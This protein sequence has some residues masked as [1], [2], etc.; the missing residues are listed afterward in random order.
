M[1]IQCSCGTKYSFEI[2]PEMAR[3][4]VRFVCPNCGLDSSEYVNQLIREELAEQAA[5]QSLPED[6]P[7]PSIASVPPPAAR[8]KISHEQKPAEPTP[9]APSASG[10]FCAKHRTV[11]ATGKCAICGTPIC[12]QCMELFG[13]FC[14][15]LCKN[16]ADLQGVAAPVYAGQKSVVEAQFWRKAGLIFG[17]VVAALVLAVGVWIWYAWFGSVPHQR[18][19]VRFDDSERSHYGA[20]RLVGDDQIVF[21]HGGIL[22]RYDLKTK[23]QVWQQTLVTQQQVADLVKSEDEE[24]ARESAK[25]GRDIG[26]VMLSGQHEKMVR[27]SLEGA[28]KLRVADENVWVGKYVQRTNPAD[29][30]ASSDYQLTR[31]DWATGKVAQQVTVPEDA[32]MFIDRSNEIVLL[33]HTEV[34]AQFVTHVSLADGAERTEEFHDPAAVTVAVAS[35]ARR[36][37]G[38]AGNS[39]GG[40]QPSGAEKLAEEAQNLNLP[41]RIA[42]PALV[43]GE[44]HR[45]Q[46]AAALQDDDPSRPRPDKNFQREAARFMLLPDLNGYIQVAVR[47][48]EE[49]IVT[50]E[51]MKA[52]PKK[53]LLDSGNVSTGNETTAVNEQLNEMQRNSGNTSVSEDQSRYQV[54]LHRPDSTDTPDWTGEVIGPPEVFPLK[55]VNVLAGGRSV[56]VFDKANK[57]LWEASLTYPIGGGNRQFGDAEPQFGDGPVVEHGDTLYVFDQ[58][59]LSAY[60]LATGNARWRLPSIGIVGLFFDDRGMIYVNTTTGNPDDIKYARQID[61]TKST[62]AVLL[63]LDPRTGKT[64]W[65]VKPGGFISYLSGKFIYT[66]ES[67]DPNP[68]DQVALS[69]TLQGLQRPPYLR[70][71]RINPKD[72]RL[73]WEHQQDRCP[74]DIRFD[75]NS[76]E[77]VFKREVQVLHYLSF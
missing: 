57:K 33:N 63:K 16:K 40:G 27:D 75:K 20:S 18:F 17:S 15:P 34:G 1:K 73:M 24:N 54:T 7:A 46:V 50:R 48:L 44:M 72:G 32:G 2:T 76:I 53:S 35:D 22:A 62:Q 74:F 64:L 6:A 43:A 5:S 23:K 13:Y 9:P 61:V 39:T 71:A 68:T 69:D 4:P 47:L 59:V 21:L 55:T 52:P 3:N 14:S 56:I 70:I 10:K 38:G 58:A 42:L 66:V 28:L 41:G 12:R 31:Y 36:T 45:Q 65:S 26:G 60:D 77:L 11:P 8:L 37:G 49:H 30:F 51:A 67:N 25:Y 19:S 29:I